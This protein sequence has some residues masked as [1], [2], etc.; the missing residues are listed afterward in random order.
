MIRG[1]LRNR[2][3]QKIDIALQATG[4]PFHGLFDRAYFDTGNILRVSV[5]GQREHQ[6]HYNGGP[7]NGCFCNHQILTQK[8]SSRQIAP[9]K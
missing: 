9:R 2:L 7:R 5:R 8:P 4:P 3:L 1:Q 6:R